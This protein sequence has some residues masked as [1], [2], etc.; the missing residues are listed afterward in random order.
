MEDINIHNIKINNLNID[1]NKSLNSFSFIPSEDENFSL[2]SD[3][4][5]NKEKINLS[6]NAFN[7][8]K[9][10]FLIFYNQD[11]LNSNAKRRKFILETQL[12]NYKIFELQNIFYQQYN[13][14]NKKNIK[15]K[16]SHD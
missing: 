1:F 2:D 8:V 13:L 12:M 15:Y 11:Y 3:S 10:D 14:L 7:N 4:Q 6:V 5:F 9:N 16:Y